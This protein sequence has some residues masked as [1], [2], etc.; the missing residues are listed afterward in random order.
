MAR[1]NPEF[2]LHLMQSMTHNLHRLQLENEHLSVMTTT[3]RVACFILQ[4]CLGMEH[5]D[6]HLT[7]PYDKHLAAAR[8]GMKPETFSRGLKDLREYGVTVE[9]NDVYIE[10][11]ERLEKFCCSNCSACPDTC[12][13]AKRGLCC[14]G[15]S[16]QA[17]AL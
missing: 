9:K 5:C 17:Q 1:Q 11:R 6:G 14:H 4:M 3:Q 16:E 12:P 15:R 7:F 2:S 8:L 13:L 10:S